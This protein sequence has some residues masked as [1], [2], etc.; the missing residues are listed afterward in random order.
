MREELALEK[1]HSIFV[2]GQ[3]MF[4]LLSGIRLKCP[5][6]ENARTQGVL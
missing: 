2:D 6:S 4:S 5:V 3:V 1:A